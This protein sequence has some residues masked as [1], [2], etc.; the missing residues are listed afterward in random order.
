MLKTRQ[1]QRKFL[2]Y[3]IDLKIVEDIVDCGRLAASA[4]NIQ[5]WHFV[6]VDD[7]ELK[8]KISTLAKNGS[9]IKDCGVAIAVFC[10]T[11]DFMIEDGS[12]ATQN[13]LNAATAYN[14]G[15]CWVAGYHRSYSK[16][17]EQLLSSP[18]DYELVSLIAIGIVDQPHPR[19]DK[20]PLEQVMSYNKFE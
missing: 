12:A 2:P 4:K 11:G 13:I 1:S 7:S 20:K 19:P 16:Q 5:P 14:L 6:V 10:K 8:T 9:F 17:V 15:S 3:S 18:Q